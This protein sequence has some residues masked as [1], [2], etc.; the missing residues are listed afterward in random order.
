VPLVSRSVLS[1]SSYAPLFALLGLVT[2]HE[3]TNLAIAF[4]SLAALLVAVLGL[5][6]LYLARVLGEWSQELGETRGKTE[7]LGAYIATYLL[8]FLAFAFD[9]WQN[10]LAIFLFIALL[11]FIYVRARLPYLNPLLLVFGFRLVEVHHRDPNCEPTDPYRVSVAIAK[12]EIK[13]GDR[14]TA[15][16][17]QRPKAE[18]GVLM[19]KKVEAHGS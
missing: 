4:F 15:A 18:I 16:F 2:W 1:A 17:M 7:E 13:E 6:M 12:G 14:V 5:L 8:P 11:A 10:V 19:V 3:H 9:H